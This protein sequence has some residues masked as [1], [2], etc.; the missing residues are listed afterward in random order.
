[1]IGPILIAGVG[2]IFFGDDAYGCEV[3]RRCAGEQFPEGVRVEDYGIRGT[4]LA[5]ELMSGYEG[6]ILIDAVA[7][8][9]EPGTLYV[10]E[11]DL[12]TAVGTPDAH[13]MD[14][15]TVFSFMKTLDGVAPRIVII[16]CDVPEPHE[17]IGLSKAVE[18]AAAS[19][20]ALVHE[21]LGKYFGRALAPAGG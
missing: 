10:I 12:E 20:I 13:S 7:R 16:G 14:L 18:H 15:Q 11:P 1:V 5:F 2:N 3:I 4:H 6:A 8:G 19:T 21:V 17:G 9:G